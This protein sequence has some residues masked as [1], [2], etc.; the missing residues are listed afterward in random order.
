MKIVHILLGDYEFNVEKGGKEFRPKKG[1]NKFNAN[2]GY[3]I[4]YPDE[5]KSET[6]IYL[7]LE[8]EFKHED[9]Q[10][11]TA[12]GIYQL[13]LEDASFDQIESIEFHMQALKEVFNK[14]STLH[15]ISVSQTPFNKAIISDEVLENLILQIQ[16][17]ERENTQK[18]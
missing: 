13:E 17:D 6:I 18:N 8:I 14:F 11:Y 7:S 5:V 3:G 16:S 15:N 1:K 9:I 12:E 10:L 2:F 4:S